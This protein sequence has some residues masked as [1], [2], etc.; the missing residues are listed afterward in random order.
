MEQTYPSDR[1]ISVQ[2]N[3]MVDLPAGAPSNA[4]KTSPT[5]RGHL[6]RFRFLYGGIATLV[7]LFFLP[8]LVNVSRYQRRIATSI[9]NSIGRPVHFD[10]ISLTVL[11]LPGFT[12]DNFVVGEDPAF[13]Y[14]PIIRAN[15]VRATLRLSSL[16][17]RRVEFSTISFTDPSVNLVHA[18]N[19]QWNIEGIMLHASQIETAPTAQ[20]RAGPAPRFPYIEATGARLNIKQEQEKL[21]FSL[22]EAE[23]ALWLP[24]PHQWHLRLRARPTRTD[25]NVSDTGIIELETTLGA[26][27][28]LSQIPLNL[29]GQWR[30]AQL[31]EA[32]R[33]LFGHDAGW[34]GQMNLTTHIRGT[35]GES[36]ISTRL[37]LIDARPADFIPEKPLT[38]E[39][40]CFA[41]A[42]GIFHAFEDLRCSWPPASSSQI[43]SIVLTG[44][45]PNVHLPREASIQITAPKIP[46]STLLTWLRATN[47]T[48]PQNLAIGGMLTGTLTYGATGS[49]SQDQP[50]SSANQWQ[51][52]LT[53][54]NAAVT[55]GEAKTPLLSGDVHLESLAHLPLPHSRNAVSATGP[56]QGFT[57]DPVPLQLGGHDPVLLSGHL[58]SVGYTLHLAGN[59][60]LERLTTL[61]QAFPPLGKGLL[62]ALPTKSP[63][64]GLFHIDLTATRPWKGTQTWQDNSVHTSKPAKTGQRRHHH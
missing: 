10:R 58:D 32:T 57:L 5:R 6:R 15:S 22:V 7:L 4:P 53:L 62:E 60:T 54:D 49:V 29:E 27:P 63:T 64:T 47:S 56:K 1:G 21:P 36:A 55:T 52:Q 8:P 42:T 31:G 16:W 11:P 13:G 20:R 12:I 41:T 9:S 37:R 50:A 43:S 51:G 34:R 59:A 2:Q 44:N 3:E 24:D 28:S 30:N 39:A 40:E 35:F 33:V 26:A 38:T 48:I 14:E 46:G 18:A 45:I 19:G 17:R 23:F 61:A 25:S